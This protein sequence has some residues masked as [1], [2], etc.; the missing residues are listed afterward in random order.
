MARGDVFAKTP[1]AL[2]LAAIFIV[3]LALHLLR[4]VLIPL[5][6]ALLV[7]FLL[8]PIVNRLERWRFGRI[9]AVLA[10]AIVAF[11]LIGG[12]GYLVTGQVLNLA[13]NLDDYAENV[14]GKIEA[15]RPGE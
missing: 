12:L 5:A 9:G 7:S 11:A 6:L 4:D 15:L 14:A 2:T 10:V 3:M 13:R 8:N 1:R